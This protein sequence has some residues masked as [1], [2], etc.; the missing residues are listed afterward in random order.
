VR[1]ANDLVLKFSKKMPLEFKGICRKAI[2]P[3]MNDILSATSAT[4][5]ANNKDGREI[6]IDLGEA[7]KKTD[8]DEDF[9]P[10]KDGVP[11]GKLFDDNS[12]DEG[13][14]DGAPSMT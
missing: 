13:T 2:I 12:S 14:K 5:K 3:Q 7:W 10:N 11:I 4:A 9:D 8:F 1:A 6:D